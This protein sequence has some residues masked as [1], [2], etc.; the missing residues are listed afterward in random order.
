MSI[1]AISD[2]HLSFNDDKPM[3]VFGENWDNHE[4]KIK[5]NWIKTV[6]DDDLV[7]LPGDF[8]W[9]MHLKDTLNDFKFLNVLPGK[10]V[11]IKGNHDYW[12]TTIKSMNDFLNS[13]KIDNISFIINNAFLF[14]D[15]IIVGTRGWTFTESENSEKMHKRELMRLENSIKYGVDNY[16]KDK[17]IICAMHYPPITK[18]MINNN[19]NSMY[20]ELMRKNNIKNCIYGHLH[21]K[22]HQEAVE[23]NINGIEL[24]LVSCDYLD[25]NLYKIENS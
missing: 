19:E 13:N 18:N 5:D 8:S 23:G 4:E 14:E 20:M 7:I 17:R 22:S 1:Y 2:L 6:K 9:A 25:F 16:G 24:K 12:W 3:N 21:G 15:T 11:L 10:K